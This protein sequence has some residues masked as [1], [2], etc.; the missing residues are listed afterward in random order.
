MKAANSERE[1]EK[2]KLYSWDKMVAKCGCAEWE[3]R[4]ENL[5]G[6]EVPG[7]LNQAQLKA[8]SFSICSLSDILEV[9]KSPPYPLITSVP[10]LP[11]TYSH[12]KVIMPNEL[13]RTS[14]SALQVVVSILSS[15]CRFHAFPKFVH[16]ITLVRLITHPLHK[17]AHIRHRAREDRNRESRIKR[18]VLR[19]SWEA[20]L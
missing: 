11:C 19:A 13:F 1:R 5:S 15:W 18:D 16:S 6:V 12:W 10:R 8:V 4:D 7:S 17:H 20:H 3:R 9:I 2:K 14:S